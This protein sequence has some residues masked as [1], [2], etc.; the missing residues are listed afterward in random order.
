MDLRINKKTLKV[1]RCAMKLRINVKAAHKKRL[2]NYA[3][4]IDN[5]PYL[6]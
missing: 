6:L 4:R 1:K 5:K 2:K 3:F